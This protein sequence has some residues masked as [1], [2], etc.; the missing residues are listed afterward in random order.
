MPREMEV[1]RKYRAE[2]VQ[3]LGAAPA[4]V[5]KILTIGVAPA[6]AALD[7][8]QVAAMTMTAAAVMNT[9]DAYSLR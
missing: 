1:L 7:P 3:R 8:I 9:P 2:E 4:E 6:D 5:K